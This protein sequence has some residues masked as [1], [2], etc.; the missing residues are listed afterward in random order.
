MKKSKKILV[1]LSLV[2]SMAASCL[3]AFAASYTDVADGSWYKSYVDYVSDMGYMKG[4][5]DGSFQ[6]DSN[7]TRAEFVTVLVNKFN[8]TTVSQVEM[9]DVPADAWY[10]TYMRRAVAANYIQ[11]YSD[12]TYRPEAYITREEAAVVL[13]RV[14]DLSPA[15]S[16]VLSFTDNA[17]I[18]DWAQ[19]MV[20]KLVAEDIICGYD[21]GSFQPQGNVTR[22][23]VA[24][25]LQNCDQ[26]LAN[27]TAT[28]APTQLPIIIN[29]GN[30]SNGSNQGTAPTRPS[31]GGGGT[32][33]T[34]TPAPTATPDP[35]A[36]PTPTPA[37]PTA[38]PIP[39][40]PSDDATQDFISD[41]GLSGSAENQTIAEN[42]IT[43][44]KDLNDTLTSVTIPDTAPT[45]NPNPEPAEQEVVVPETSDTFSVSA[46]AKYYNITLNNS[47][48]DAVI[49][50]GTVEINSVN[51]AAAVDTTYLDKA[52]E[53]YKPIINDA[54]VSAVS[55]EGF[56]AET[57]AAVKQA[58]YLPALTDLI[59][60]SGE[61]VQEDLA[62]NEGTPASEIFTGSFTDRTEMFTKY[63]DFVLS[64]LEETVQPAVEAAGGTADEYDALFMAARDMCIAVYTSAASIDELDYT[65]Y[66]DPALALTNAYEIYMN[67]TLTVAE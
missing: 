18:S 66:D 11:G 24:V 46:L 6:P 62:A 58:L 47:G 59:Y 9:S 52:Y 35:E 7:I 4:Y 8:P 27:A 41:A 53:V 3:T 61:M 39:S 5:E 30:G 20:N 42:I 67:Y 65:S 14:Y 57:N 37:T 33:S 2:A 48:S 12:D 21:D 43:S 1:S 34:P 17:S 32:T 13:Y 31:G 28:T 36:T 60:K 25:L 64:S 50:D 55:S 26:K 29:G 44:S 45:P 38:I 63:F 15:D 40:E 19:Q 56:D 22:A 49:A 54:L 23:E 16:N 51:D 10:N